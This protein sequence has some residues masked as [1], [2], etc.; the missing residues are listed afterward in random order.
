MDGLWVCDKLLKIAREREQLVAS[1]LL[2]NELQDMAHYRAL[3]GDR[4]YETPHTNR[5][6]YSYYAVYPPQGF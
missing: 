5:M 1:I 2:N 4:N 3:M 6:A